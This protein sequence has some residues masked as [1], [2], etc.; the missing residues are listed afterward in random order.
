[1]HGHLCWQQLQVVLLPRVHFVGAF[2]QAKST[3]PQLACRGRLGVHLPVLH[4]TSH[5]EQLP[6]GCDAAQA[7]PRRAS[8]GASE[9]AFAGHGVAIVVV[10]I[11]VVVCHGRARSIVGV[12]S[13]AGYGW[14]CTAGGA[15][16]T[17]RHAARQTRCCLASAMAVRFVVDAG[18]SKRCAL[19]RLLQ[20]ALLEDRPR[21]GQRS[22]SFPCPRRCPCSRGRRCLS[23]RIRG[24]GVGKPKGGDSLGFAG[25]CRTTHLEDAL[26]FLEAAW[27]ICSG[28]FGGGPQRKPRRRHCRCFVGHTCWGHGHEHL[29]VVLGRRTRLAKE[30]ATSSW[31][32]CIVAAAVVCL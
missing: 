3:P 16:I 21:S 9:A 6:L 11:I 23:T 1:M 27:A 8:G 5:L 2:H 12:G 29:V 13:Q 15:V 7:R 31:R 14:G 25:R 18:E 20:A 19:L 24:G 32:V 26:R 10:V 22:G 4:D 28:S 17:E 30:Q